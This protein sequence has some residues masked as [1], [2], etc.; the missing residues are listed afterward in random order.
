MTVVPD[1]VK[2]G[3]Y[4]DKDG[5]VESLEVAL[6]YDGISREDLT[7]VVSM[8]LL[9]DP[10]GYVASLRDGAGAPYQHNELG[11]TMVFPRDTAPL[12]AMPS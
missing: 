3:A 5:H 1:K 9:L 4:Y 8:A 7:H 10:T 6:N 11:A 2:V 12:R